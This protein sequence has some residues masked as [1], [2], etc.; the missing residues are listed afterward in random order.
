MKIPEIHFR[1]NLLWLR[2]KFAVSQSEIAFQVEKRSTTISNWENGVSEPSI[3]ELAGICQYFGVSVDSVLFENFEVGKVI[4]E[5][6][7]R[8]FQE[9]GKGTGKRIG[10]GMASDKQNV[11]FSESAANVPVPGEENMIWAVLQTLRQMDVKLDGVR[12]GVENIEKKLP[13]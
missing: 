7:V 8:N 3:S 4:S 2:K 6:D 10:K 1:K 13:G 9:K 11:E 12:A 5:D